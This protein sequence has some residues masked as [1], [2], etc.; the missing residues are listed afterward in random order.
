MQTAVSYPGEGMVNDGNAG[1]FI[2][3]RW[4][5]SLFTH[6]RLHGHIPTYY[7]QIVALLSIY[8][9]GPFPGSPIPGYESPTDESILKSFGEMARL[10]RMCSA[11][12]TVGNLQ[13]Q[14]VNIISLE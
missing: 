11:E 9:L 6:P 7:L 14:L 12:E 5:L 3:N 4:S 13:E 10:G 1:P 8:E 2:S